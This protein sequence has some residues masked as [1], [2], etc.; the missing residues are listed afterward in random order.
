MAATVAKADKGRKDAAA[1]VIREFL[2]DR[3]SGDRVIR[4]V[5]HRGLDVMQNPEVELLCTCRNVLVHKRGWDEFGEIAEGI[6]KLGS[7]RALI[8]ASLYPAGHMPI[9]LDNENY[10]IVDATIGN[11]VA[12]LLHQ[13]IFMM[14][15]NFA[16]LYKLPRKVWDSRSIGR[17][18]L[19]D[20]NP[21]QAQPQGKSK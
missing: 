19:G 5:I 2:T 21:R 18:F 16:H 17:T 9:A 14:D 3:Y 13:Q 11:W 6:Q 1:E 8:G 15:Q 4:E 20:P 7:E 12:E 10:L